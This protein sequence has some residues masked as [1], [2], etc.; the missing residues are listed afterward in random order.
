MTLIPWS[1]GRP[2][3]TLAPSHFNEPLKKAGAIPDNA[4]R[5]KHNRYR[6]LEENYIFTPI[7]FESLGSM[8]PIT[9]LLVTSYKFYSIKFSFKAF[10][11]IFFFYFPF[12]E[13]SKSSLQLSR[14]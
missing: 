4:E 13:A 1:H 9:M 10:S 11:T 8:G 2:I 14:K 12:F 6:N 7:A 3:I 5:H